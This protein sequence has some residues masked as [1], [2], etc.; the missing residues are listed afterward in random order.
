MRRHCKWCGKLWEASKLEP[1]PYFC[2]LCE[3]YKGVWNALRREAAEDASTDGK[4]H[5]D[6]RG[7]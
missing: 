2:P 1:D 5:P 4:A 6:A 7:K 3:E